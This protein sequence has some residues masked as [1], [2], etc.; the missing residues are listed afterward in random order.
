ME[1]ACRTSAVRRIHAVH[2]L[3]A[4]LTHHRSDA[5]GKRSCQEVLSMPSAWRG[6]L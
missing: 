6:V 4:A 3:E 1:S 2:V 5:A